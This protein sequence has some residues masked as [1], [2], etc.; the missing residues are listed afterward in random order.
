MKRILIPSLLVALAIPAAAQQA[1]LKAE[2][3]L[4]TVQEN[5]DSLTSRI[6]ITNATRTAIRYIETITSTDTKDLALSDKAAVYFIEPREY[7]QALDLYQGRKYKE[8]Q[9]KFAAVKTAYKPVELLAGNHGVLAGFYEME[10][11]RKLGDLEGLSTALGAFKKDGLTREHHLRQLELNVIWDTVRIKNWERLQ[12]LA[13]ERSKERLPDYQRAQIAYFHALAHEQAGRL[14]EALTSYQVA[15]VADAGAS[16]D[17][18]RLSALQIMK[19]IKANPEV[20]T[21]I[22]LWGGPKEKKSGIGYN[23]LIEAGAVARLY[24][25]SLGGGKPLPSEF[26]DLVKYKASDM[27]ASKE[28]DKPKDA[29]KKEGS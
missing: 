3:A 12:V 7:S 15:M 1:P 20:Q 11:L 5:G 28:A 8:A 10:C 26:K 27:P 29:G 4:I 18:A 23:R 6:W 2:A 21:A 9:E 22:E 16:E 25:L 13:D 14:D 24:E 17:V 19:I